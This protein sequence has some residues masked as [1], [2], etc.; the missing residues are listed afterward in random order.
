MINLATGFGPGALG[1]GAGGCSSGI[2]DTVSESLEW[3]LLAGGALGGLGFGVLGALCLGDG[4]A[5]A[6]PW[7]LG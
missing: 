7:P 4:A 3:S 2:S 1:A 5:G 6:V